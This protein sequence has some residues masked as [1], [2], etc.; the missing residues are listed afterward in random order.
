MHGTSVNPLRADA[1]TAGT[2]RAGDHIRCWD[3]QHQG[4][5]RRLTVLSSPYLD[6]DD[7]LV[8]KVCYEDGREDTVLTS[9]IGLTGY[10]F[11]GS[12]SVIAIR[13]EQTDSAPSVRYFLTRS[14]GHETEVTKEEFVLAERAAGF[15]NLHGPSS[16]PATAGF[17]DND[18][19]GRVRYS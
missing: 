14:G 18:V 7:D 13:D 9:S 12:W 10:R 17:S 8:V 15:K 6:D 19:I 11:D 4:S 2:I 16:E 1:L 3:P 5:E